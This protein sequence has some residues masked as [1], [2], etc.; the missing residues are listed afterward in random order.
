MLFD[1]LDS[2][3][4]SQVE[5]VTQTERARHVAAHS[6]SS[7]Y[8][9]IPV[10]G[11][12]PRRASGLRRPIAANAGDAP[13]R[14]IPQSAPAIGVEGPA[15]AFALELEDDD[16]DDDGTDSEGGS[17]YALMPDVVGAP[18]DNADSEKN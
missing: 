18:A 8:M 16:D 9:Q 15:D 10:L 12:D 14:P 13:Y 4:R 11:G 17:V 1:F 7:P 6:G 3:R 5:S 2:P